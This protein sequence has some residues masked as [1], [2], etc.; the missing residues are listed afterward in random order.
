MQHM[1]FKCLWVLKKFMVELLKAAMFKI[2][3]SEKQI[4][5][6]HT[7]TAAGFYDFSYL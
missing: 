4:S 6:T 7:V 5:H 3:N 2:Y 1:D